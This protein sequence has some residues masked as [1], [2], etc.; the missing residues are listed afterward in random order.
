MIQEGIQTGPFPKEML[1]LQGLTPDTFVWREGLADWVKAGTLPDLEDLFNEDSAF[2]A[3]AQPLPPE[4]GSTEVEGAPHRDYPK[5]EGQYGN[6]W[7]NG[8]YNSRGNNGSGYPSPYG[9]NNGQPVPHTNWLAPAIVATVVGALF[10]CIGM[11]FGII[12]ITKASAANR[13]Y[14][15]GDK[16]RGDMA[17]S[18][19]RTMVIIAFVLAAIGIILVA[20]GLTGD[21]TRILL[22]HS[23]L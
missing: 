23:V 20:S 12:G 1:R 10:S 15:V 22:K 21:L 8:Q 4:S 13:F 19:A 17:N 14:D 6:S 2:G 9:G 3:Y 11:I 7:N 5:Y 18:S 16:Q